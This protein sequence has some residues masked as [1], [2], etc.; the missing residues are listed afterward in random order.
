MEEYRNMMKAAQWNSPGWQTTRKL[1]GLAF[2]IL[3]VAASTAFAASRFGGDDDRDDDARRSYAIGL[4]GDLPYSDAQAL[5]G[6]P[7]LTAQMNRHHLSF[8][9]PPPAPNPGNP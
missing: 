6:A 3:L 5:T 2:A 1:A 7:N 4:W 9:P 8:P